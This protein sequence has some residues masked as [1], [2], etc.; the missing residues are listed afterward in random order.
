MATRQTSTQASADLRDG[1]KLYLRRAR[2][3]LPRL[4]RQAHA[5]QRIVYSDLAA[6]LSIPNVRNLNYPLGAI[7]RALAALGR[8]HKLAIPGIQA[9]VVNK[10]TGVPGEGIGRFVTP[11]DFREY[12]PELKRRHIQAAV[13]DIC[14]FPRWDWVLEQFGLEPLP[15]ISELLLAAAGRAGGGE[16]SERHRA[17]KLYVAAHPELVGLNLDVGPGK[18][19]QPLASGDRIDVLFRHGQL[20]VGVEV[21]SDLSDEKDVIRGLFQ[22]VKYQAVLEAQQKARNLVPHCRVVLVLQG[23]LSARCLRIKN[24]LGVTVLTHVYPTV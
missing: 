16:E 12:S 10:R 8:Q 1:Q 13:N 9:L 6:E 4:V 5:N 11:L 3:I 7:G 15:P 24:T 20:Q 19:E 21:K 23:G 2:L 17:L 18:V 22:C 14:T